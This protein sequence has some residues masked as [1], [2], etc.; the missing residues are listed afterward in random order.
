MS[1]PLITGLPSGLQGTAHSN[2]NLSALTP[3]E[4]TNH[5]NELEQAVKS[6]DAQKVTTA[7][8]RLLT[9]GKTIAAQQI[10]KKNSRFNPLPMA[11]RLVAALDAPGVFWSEEIVYDTLRCARMFIEL[12]LIKAQ[13]EKRTLD[14]ADQAAM[15]G[16][17]NK[18]QK[19]FQ[20]DEHVCVR[21]ELKCCR[22]ALKPLKVIDPEIFW[23][24]LTNALD[25]SPSA[26]LHLGKRIGDLAGQRSNGEKWL[27]EAIY[28]NWMGHFARTNIDFFNTIIE[29]YLQD[30]L[31]CLE[32]AQMG[33]EFL[34][35][36]LAHGTPDVQWKALTGNV[37]LITLLNLKRQ[38]WD[39]FGHMWEVR[40]RA[41]QVLSVFAKHSNRKIAETTRNALGKR[42][43]IE[44]KESKVYPLF[45]ALDKD[46]T[47][48]DQWTKQF[49]ENEQAYVEEGLRRQ[50]ELKQLD[51]SLKREEELLAQQ[52]ANPGASLRGITSQSKS[53]LQKRSE[54][55][56]LRS[57]CEALKENNAILHEQ[58][59]KGFNQ[60]LD[61]ALDHTSPKE[62]KHPPEFCCPITHELMLDPVRAED[63]KHYESTALAQAIRS[64]SIS[65]FTQQ[66]FTLKS[67]AADLEFKA[68]IAGYTFMLAQK[69]LFGQT[70]ETQNLATAVQYLEHSAKQGFPAA[71]YFMGF[72][73]DE[74]IHKDLE[75][76]NPP[77]R[78]D[79]YWYW[80]ALMTQMS[81]VLNNWLCLKDK[82]K[83]KEWYTKA[84]A[85]SSIPLRTDITIRKFV[86]QYSREI[87]GLKLLSA[88]TGDMEGE[89]SQ[90]F[91][92]QLV[93]ERLTTPDSIKDE[94]LQIILFR[95]TIHM[96]ANCRLGDLALQHARE[97]AVAQLPPPTDAILK[98]LKMAIQ[99]YR[100]GHA[101]AQFLQ[102]VCHASGLEVLAFQK[103]PPTL[104]QLKATYRNWD[105]TLIP[106]IWKSSIESFD[107]KAAAVKSIITKS[108]F[109]QAVGYY[110]RSAE[111]GHVQA[112]FNLGYTLFWYKDKECES[113]FQKAADQGHRDAM[114]YMGI[115]RLTRKEESEA[116]KWFYKAAEKGHCEAQ[117]L[118]AS[119]MFRD[120]N[121]V[122][123][124]K[125]LKD[126]AKQD[127]RDA[128][129]DL[130]LCLING[131]VS[132]QE[133]KAEGVEWI[134]KATEGGYW[135]ACLAL[136]E[137][138]TNAW[139][140]DK[141]LEEAKKWLE[142]GHAPF[143]A[144]ELLKT[145]F[146]R[147]TRKTY[148]DITSTF[149]RIF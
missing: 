88:Y 84:A 95:L 14:T 37:G 128:Q 36:M 130:G 15:E 136:S 47:I 55:E 27:Y 108:N 71:Q 48:H 145:V 133:D 65:S 72:L 10:L 115:L 2:G 85:S 57:E 146:S 120:K 34:A 22:E 77:K 137:C 92:F 82:S 148:A 131:G 147:I 121:E 123:G 89:M 62:Q 29:D 13:K 38:K 122:E 81:T 25:F 8:Q 144:L 50:E 1:A 124:V 91:Q 19:H 32:L 7:A 126:A 5:V 141:D 119:A 60:F 41:V 68:E 61:G 40:Y 127:H 98:V 111:Q 66:P 53:L 18:V 139:G 83:S 100:N 73:S 134:R 20:K 17:L 6:N 106:P 28:I 102:G 135:K 33:V 112:Q 104:D 114:F 142:K 140:V 129:L 97:M 35:D 45:A 105:D 56:E 67:L 138:Y 76:Q 44:G 54:I 143:N 107:Q 94:M 87:A 49:K 59:L 63:G 93:V 70:G 43:L 24:T 51:A 132:S 9:E 117:Y 58:L 26:V 64:N 96:F 23:D 116:E 109:T 90:A 52:Q 74:R 79:D 113:W 30:N 86:S 16:P 21:Y 42:R 125:W 12:A 78:R 80:D 69:Y 149:S 3:M 31:N 46:P 118:T 11:I 39:V 103:K 4:L 110:R 75:L 101:H 99:L